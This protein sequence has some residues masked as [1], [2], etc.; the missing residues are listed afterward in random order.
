MGHCTY[1]YA[2]IVCVNQPLSVWCFI[3]WFRLLVFMTGFQFPAFQLLVTPDTG[4]SASQ[5]RSSSLTHVQISLSFLILCY[6][7]RPAIKN[8]TGSFI[9]TH[10]KWSI[11]GSH[12]MQNISLVHQSWCTCIWPVKKEWLSVSKKNLKS[13]MECRSNFCYMWSYLH[14][15][16]NSIYL[17]YICSYERVVSMSTICVTDKFQSDECAVFLDKEGLFCNAWSVL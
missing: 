10:N 5:L 13:E 1:T 3:L 15:N 11:C 14:C 7:F 17:L 6:Y 16:F 8:L 4:H 9:H 12:Y 2:C